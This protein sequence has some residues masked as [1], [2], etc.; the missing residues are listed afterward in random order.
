MRNIIITL[1]LFLTAIGIGVF[2]WFQ[3][4]PVSIRQGC[5]NWIVDLPGELYLTRDS[6]KK[7]YDALYESCLHRE[8]LK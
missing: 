4:R 2:Y 7:D 1:S 6:D 3:L 8:G 5:H